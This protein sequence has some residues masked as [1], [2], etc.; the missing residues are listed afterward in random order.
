M[1]D[2]KVVEGIAML[3]TKQTNRHQESKSITISTIRTLTL[4]RIQDCCCHY[5]QC[6]TSAGQ[7]RPGRAPKTY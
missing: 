4:S 2:P 3:K 1:K 7:Q 6:T 5:A